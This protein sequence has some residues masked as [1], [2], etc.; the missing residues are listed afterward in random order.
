MDACVVGFPSMRASV[1]VGLTDVPGMA[2]I[3]ALEADGWSITDDPLKL[4]CR[5]RNLFADLGVECSTVGAER[6]G[7]KIAVEIRSFLGLS[8]LRDLEEAV[9]QYEVY[10]A[11]L[12]V[13]QP[14]RPLD[15][16]APAAPTRRC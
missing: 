1:G 3:R 4:E 10:R 13:T 12:A 9:G 16:A 2:P 14:D 8:A 6:A 15:L 7:R 11:V 5:D